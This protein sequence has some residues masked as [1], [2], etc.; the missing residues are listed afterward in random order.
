M[1]I[2]RVKRMNIFMFVDYIVFYIF[3]WFYQGPYKQDRWEIVQK[4]YLK[5]W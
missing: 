2:Q 1:Y 3:F 5:I 4:A